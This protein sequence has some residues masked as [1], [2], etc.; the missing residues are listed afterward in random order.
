M[1]KELLGYRIQDHGDYTVLYHLGKPVLGVYFHK[2]ENAVK[3]AEW[4]LREMVSRMEFYGT[5]PQIPRDIVPEG[6]TDAQWRFRRDA[7][8]YGWEDDVLTAT[9]SW[10]CRLEGTHREVK[11]VVV[12]GEEFQRDV[13][14]DVVLRDWSR[15]MTSKES[16]DIGGKHW[17][18]V[19]VTSEYRLYVSA[20]QN[21]FVDED[22]EA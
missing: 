20:K 21:D 14:E 9:I 15:L 8:D 11:K 10:E 3:A 18:M 19:P 7:V 6:V 5:K 17:E 12:E 13:S 2:K 22:W 4:A 16:W 1:H